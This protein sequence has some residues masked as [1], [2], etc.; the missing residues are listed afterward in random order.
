MVAVAAVEEQ[1]LGRV[2]F[3]RI[4]VDSLEERTVA[5]VEDIA[6]VD[7]VVAVAHIEVVVHIEVVTRIIGE[8]KAVGEVELRDK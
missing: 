8:D 7:S 3:H 4:L 6:A 1:E 2:R 5:V